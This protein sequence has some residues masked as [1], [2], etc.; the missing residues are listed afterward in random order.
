MMFTYIDTCYFLRLIVLISYVFTN[1]WLKDI[2]RC[3]NS[4]NLLYLYMPIDNTT[5]QARIVMFS[6]AKT[7][8]QKR[9]KYQKFLSIFYIYF[10]LDIISFYVNSVL[11][12]I[13]I[14]KLT[15][16]YIYFKKS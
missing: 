9:I 8:V 14:K 2:L 10:I 15:S 5:W 16:I 13:A 6:I 4:S 3:S 1:H 12:C 11:N 7:V